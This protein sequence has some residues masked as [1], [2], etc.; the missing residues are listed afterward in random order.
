LED[1][2]GILLGGCGFHVLVGIKAPAVSSGE[3]GDETVDAFQSTKR[4][5]WAVGPSIC[6]LVSR[7]ISESLPV[8]M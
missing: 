4:W 8:L 5:G 7:S 2:K 1:G 6:Q 3:L